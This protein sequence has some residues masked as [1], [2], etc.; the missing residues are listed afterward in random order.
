MKRS[1][2]KSEWS[3][4]LCSIPAVSNMLAL[5]RHMSKTHG[6]DR[7]QILCDITCETCNKAFP[8]ENACRRH[9][10]TVHQGKYKF[11]CDICQQGFQC[12]DNYT[13]HMNKHKG[14]RRVHKCHLCPS[15]FSHEKSLLSHFRSVHSS[16]S[17]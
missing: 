16:D 8:S 3:C 10:E 15:A 7:D 13:A 9:I 1:S 5:V 14:I 2:E 17:P 6:I 4:P 11:K 12:D